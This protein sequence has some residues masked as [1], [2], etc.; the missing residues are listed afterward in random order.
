MIERDVYL[1]GQY[2]SITFERLRRLLCE[3]KIGNRIF[4]DI[5]ANIGIYSLQVS[6]LFSR[7]VAF[8]P[9]PAIR[10]RL[11]DNINLNGYENIAVLPDA[12]GATAE[13]LSFCVPTEDNENH[14]VA[15]FSESYMRS[16]GIQY[17]TV[18]V[19][20]RP[21]DTVLAAD[22]FAVSVIKLD[23]EG[24]E[25]PALRGMEALVDASRPLIIIE[26]TEESQHRMGHTA[27]DVFAW[28]YR[29]KYAL[30]DE[31]TFEVVTAPATTNLFALPE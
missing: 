10:E 29:H 2:E 13:E 20:V 24:F 30:Y 1:Y 18:T 22:L 16:A 31:R 11:R 23:V 5:G 19:S 27:Q 17:R 4:V 8:E 6:G 26:V 28:F 21:L 12:I 25:L 15:G 7:V 3:G 14:G 9:N